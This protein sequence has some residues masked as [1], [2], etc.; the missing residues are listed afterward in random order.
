M[1]ED[2]IT[3]KWQQGT[4]LKEIDVPGNSERLVY[5]NEEERF[6]PNPINITAFNKNTSKS[7]MLRGRDELEI[8]LHKEA[9]TERID[10]GK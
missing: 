7:I 6:Y 2:T 4:V 3:L 1:L 5:V 10:I 8:M 9:F